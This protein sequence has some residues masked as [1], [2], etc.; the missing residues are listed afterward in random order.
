MLGPLVD[1]CKVH[2]PDYSIPAALDWFSVD[3]YHM[4]GKV[5]GRFQGNLS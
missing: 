3:I 2:H 4:D 1:S 5:E